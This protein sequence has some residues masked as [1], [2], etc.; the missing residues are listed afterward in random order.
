MDVKKDGDM[1]LA[2]LNNS[3]TQSATPRHS[4]KYATTKSGSGKV[5][6]SLLNFVTLHPEWRPPAEAMALIQNVREKLA[7]DAIE[8]PQQHAIMRESLHELARSIMG[9]PSG[10]GTLPM[11]SS[12]MHNIPETETDELAALETLS[13]T[14]PDAP[15]SSF[16]AAVPSARSN[17][18]GST[19]SIGT[20]NAAS[21]T[22]HRSGLAGIKQSSEKNEP[23]WASSS[24]FYPMPFS[25]VQPV[26][27]RE[28]NAQAMEMSMNALL[29][30]RMLMSSSTTHRLPNTYGS[31]TMAA[32]PVNQ[33]SRY[34]MN[35]QSRFGATSTAASNIWGVPDQSHFRPNDSMY[36]SDDNGLGF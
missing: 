22:T 19:T 21:S 9:A 26:N 15:P 2:E 31:T 11:A 10:L 34:P 14:N 17:R 6:L 29:V 27:I 7:K 23:E 24:L 33:Q 16:S 8:N 4:V 32:N 5:E 36:G 12:V 35:A 30:N 1:R 20:A 25:N 28:R 13:S 18:S 3:S